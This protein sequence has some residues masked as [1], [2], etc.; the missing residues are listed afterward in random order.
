MFRLCLAAALVVAVA[1]LPVK[2]Q[3][4]ALNYKIIE[5]INSN[6]NSTWK[7]GVNE[8]FANLNI[9]SVKRLM[10][11]TGPKYELKKKRVTFDG[12]LPT[13]FD[14]RT[15]WP[16]CIGP[17]LDQAD[18]GSCWAFGAAETVSDRLCISQ[19]AKGNN[20]TFLQLA[21]LDLVSCDS[22]FLKPNDGCQGGQPGAALDYAKSTG[23]VTEKC[24]PYLKSEGGPIPTCTD[25]PCLDFVSTPKCHKSCADGS[26][27][28]G[29][30][31]KLS[32]VYG[33]EDIASEIAKNG[34]VEA[35][36][37]VYEDF[38]HYKSGVY[39]HTTGQALGGHA[40]KIIGF[41]EENGDKYWLV[42]NSW[43]TKW[44]DNG[45]FKI[46]RGT[47]ECGIEDGAVTGT[48]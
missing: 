34:P 20:A 2:D 5:T 41:G 18:C 35:A 26:S 46:L 44:G 14:S 13:N 6:P 25:E 28:E 47:D 8:N 12:D 21:P 23:L 40:I 10:G 16:G 24:L 43:T 42:Q 31:H 22:G 17:I 15:N 7:A 33:V 11:V 45:L 9:E 3:E 32:D 30:K 27:F 36:F 48:F 39:K 38:V 29:D 1:S 37:T 19:S 4:P